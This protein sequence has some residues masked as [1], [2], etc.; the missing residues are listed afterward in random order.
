MLAAAA[1]LG[2]ACLG[3]MFDGMS[4]NTDPDLDGGEDYPDDPVFLQV[5][6]AEP[7]SWEDE[8]IDWE[9]EADFQHEQV[10]DMPMPQPVSA[11]QIDMDADPHAGHG[12]QMPPQHQDGG[13]TP[14]EGPLRLSNADDY[15]EGTSAAEHIIGRQGDDTIIGNGGTDTL[16]GWAGNDKLVSYGNGGHLSGNT[17]DDTLEARKSG[18]GQY[19]M[20]GGEGDDT[21]I[22][23][24]ENEYGWGH[25]SFH[26]YGDE[27]A[28]TFRFVGDGT[29]NAPMVSRIDDFDPAVDSIWLDDEE[30]DLNNL[31]EG[32]RIIEYHGQQWLVLNENAIVGLE[33]VRWDA[34]EGVPTLPNSNIEM[35]FH[36]FPTDLASMPGVSFRG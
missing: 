2:I 6:G 30:L 24:M 27:G 22:M 34:P 26:V 19:H 35:H 17:A 28:D 8:D 21:L 13:E 9:E 14:S 29:P 36:A 32:M 4:D 18:Y 11:P 12:D 31:P 10:H 20:H 16:V 25:Q 5:P 1:L 23:H 7:L 33:P 3:F 15:H